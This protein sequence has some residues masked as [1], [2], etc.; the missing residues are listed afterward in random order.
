LA[1]VDPVSATKSY[2]I[3]MVCSALAALLTQPHE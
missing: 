1:S 3:S 2:A